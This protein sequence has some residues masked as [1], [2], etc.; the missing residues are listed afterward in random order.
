MILALLAALA[1]SAAASDSPYGILL[2]EA[3]AAIAKKDYPAARTA[4]DRAEAVAPA[5]DELIPNED[6]ARLEFYRGVVEWRA[7]DKDVAALE[8]WRRALV[9]SPTYLPD[10]AV[11]P[12]TE[13]QDAF[14]A[15]ASEVKGYEQL[16]VGA[17]AYAGDALIFVDGV[18]ADPNAFLIEGDHFIQIRCADGSVV[19]SW[20]SFGPPP[21]D[22]LVICNGGSFPVRGKTTRTRPTKKDPEAPPEVEAPPEKAPREPVAKAPKEPAAKEPREPAAR[23]PRE[24]EAPVAEAPVAPDPPTPDREPGRGKRVLAWSLAGTGG[25][26]LAGGGAA[27]WML[28]EPAWKEGQGA[29]PNSLTEAEATSLEGELKSAQR[30]TQ[31]LLGGGVVLLGGGVVVGTVDAHVGVAPGRLLVS[32]RF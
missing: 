29:A 24:P 5:N 10:P 4:L 30:L 14:Y 2:D 20:Y 18:R 23:E 17:P 6:L 8:A 9:L 32:G 26:L 1:G 11:L 27:N 22:W 25:L 12:E 19:G 3:R 31:V 16:P 13:G 7:G 21:P 15:L 28:V